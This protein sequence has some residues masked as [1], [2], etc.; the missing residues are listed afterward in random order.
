[1]FSTLRLT[2]HKGLLSTCVR[3]CNGRDDRLLGD[4]VMRL[5]CED[6]SPLA[7]RRSLADEGNAALRT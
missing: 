5:G 4:D 7:A 1:M 6:R 3:Q 2:C